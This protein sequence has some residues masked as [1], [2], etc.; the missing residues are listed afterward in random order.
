[1]YESILLVPEGTLKRAF[2]RL[3]TQDELRDALAMNR[4]FYQN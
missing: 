1:M 4:R 2:V 3:R